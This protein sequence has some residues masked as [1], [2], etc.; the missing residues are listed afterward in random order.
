[1][2][3][4]EDDRLVKRL[5]IASAAMSEWTTCERAFRMFA[6]PREGTAANI[7]HAAH[8]FSRRHNTDQILST[9]HGRDFE[10]RIG[11][12]LENFGVQDHRHNPLTYEHVVYEALH[13]EYARNTAPATALLGESTYFDYRHDFNQELQRHASERFAE[14]HRQGHDLSLLEQQRRASLPPP[15]QPETTAH[16]GSQQEGP[17]QQRPGRGPPSRSQSSTVSGRPDLPPTMRVMRERE[18]S[19][20]QRTSPEVAADPPKQGQK[21][22]QHEIA[23]SPFEQAQPPESG[24]SPPRKRTKSK[25]AEAT[26]EVSVKSSLL[27]RRDIC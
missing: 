21:R 24:P 19:E 25:G 15:G 12:R 17:G 20:L 16:E 1:M 14:L 26:P 23:P 7:Q 9:P 4:K 22:G 2:R 10:E 13:G 3:D 27:S 18:L 6:D 11:R 8:Q 5:I